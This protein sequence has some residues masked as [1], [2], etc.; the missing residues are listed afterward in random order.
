MSMRE[1]YP[2]I[3][4]ALAF[5]GQGG[6]KLP[7]VP[8]FK[9]YAALPSHI[10]AM[11]RA[12]TSGEDGAAERYANVSNKNLRGLS[13]LELINTPFG[14]KAVERFLLDLGNYLGVEDMD[15][16]QSDFG[17]RS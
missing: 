10:R 6:V 4:T 15:R 3:P 13:V 14:Q 11:L 12:V 2:C 9:D 16:F 7:A 5:I 17:K 1:A 8:R